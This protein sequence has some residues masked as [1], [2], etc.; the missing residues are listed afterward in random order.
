[1]NVLYAY[2]PALGREDG[3][4]QGRVEEGEELE[5]EACEDEYLEDEK[6][7]EDQDTLDMLAL[8]MLERQELEE[9][10]NNSS[11]TSSST[12]SSSSSSSSS[13]M[14]LQR[15]SRAWLHVVVR[16]P[17]SPLSVVG[18][19]AVGVLLFLRLTSDRSEFSSTRGETASIV[20]PVCLAFTR[21]STE[22][23]PE[24]DFVGHLTRLGLE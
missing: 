14:L 10:N 19:A 7:D 15:K 9:S 22:N 3:R 6:V 13:K 12:S 21:G 5:L 4:E 20:V 16:P 11:S 2:V 8:Q 17:S 1:M 23:T 18:E 24:G